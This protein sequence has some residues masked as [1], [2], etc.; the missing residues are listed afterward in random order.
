MRQQRWWGAVLWVAAGCGALAAQAAAPGRIQLSL[1]GLSRRAAEVSEVTLDG[2]MLQLGVRM[3]SAR[4][5]DPGARAVL[6]RLEGVYVK[7][8]RFQARGEYSA[9]DLDAIRRQLQA[10]GWSHIVSVHSRREHE[11][12]DVYVM[13]A[14]QGVAG[15]AVIA[16]YPRELRVVNLVGPVDPAELGRLGGHFG[17]PRVDAHSVPRTG[18]GGEAKPSRRKP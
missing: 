8:L 1:G 16:A 12:V 13:S 11:D 3:L 4:E 15:M 5:S 18:H 7:S 10:P 6:A 14:A 2:P 9:R 17:I